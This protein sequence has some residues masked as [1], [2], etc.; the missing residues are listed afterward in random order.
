MKFRVDIGFTGVVNTAEPG[1]TP[2]K[3]CKVEVQRGCPMEDG[4]VAGGVQNPPEGM[5]LYLHP[6]WVVPE[7]PDVCPHS[8]F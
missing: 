4:E 3:E 8:A 7:E 6:H 1:I 5:Q 2:S